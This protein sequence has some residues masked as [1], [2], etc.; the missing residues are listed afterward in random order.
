MHCHASRYDSV[1]T[2]AEGSGSDI[3]YIV[4]PVYNTMPGK[5]ISLKCSI[6]FP[7]C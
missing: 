2:S 1:T 4:I 6:V 5:H 3:V 7:K